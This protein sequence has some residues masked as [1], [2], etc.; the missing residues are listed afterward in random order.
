M[1]DS[2]FKKIYERTRTFLGKVTTLDEVLYEMKISSEELME[3]IEIVSEHQERLNSITR[4]Y[5][6]FIAEKRDLVFQ[7]FKELGISATQQNV[8][9]RVFRTFKQEC[10]D[11]RKEYD[12][13]KLNFD[14]ATNIKYALIQRKDYLK[15]LIEYFNCKKEIEPCIM[16][17]KSF[18]RKILAVI[19]D[20]G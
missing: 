1:L 16:A 18:A 4:R 10:S 3:M 14:T 19:G 15:S 5:D 11:L 13:I 6:E 8:E 2:R 20:K 7:K 9:D 12:D 17:N